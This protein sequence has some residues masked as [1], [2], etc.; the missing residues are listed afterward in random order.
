MILKDLH[1]LHSETIKLCGYIV[2]LYIINLDR[3]LPSSRLQCPWPA[4]VSSLLLIEMQKETNGTTN[5]GTMACRSG[6][7]GN[8][9]R[10][11]ISRLKKACSRVL[12]ERLLFVGYCIL[13]YSLT[14]LN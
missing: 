13:S 2:F 8:T 10:N 14:E 4:C 9:P 3:S 1:T 5:V 11:F 7:G 6:G 12:G